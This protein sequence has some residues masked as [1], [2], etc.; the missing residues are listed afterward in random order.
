[1]RAS[2]QIIPLLFSREDRHRVFSDRMRETLD[3]QK[4][5]VTDAG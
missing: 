3:K 4:Q 5:I 2:D 1:M